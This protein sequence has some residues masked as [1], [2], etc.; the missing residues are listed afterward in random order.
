[1]TNVA[2]HAPRG[3]NVGDPFGQ[4][5]LASLFAEFD[6]CGVKANRGIIDEYLAVDLGQVDLAAV[7]VR[8]HA[9]RAFEIKGNAE[10]AREIVAG[11]K[12]QD[13]VRR[14]SCAQDGGGAPLRA[15]A[16]ANRN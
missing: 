15:I 11:A 12:R 8:D 9:D 13:G 2:Q 3:G 7:A 10:L 4:A 14:A 5:A 6:E 1:M 16:A